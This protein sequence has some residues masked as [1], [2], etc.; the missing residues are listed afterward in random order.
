[1]YSLMADSPFGKI[2]T[3]FQTAAPRQFQ[4]TPIAPFRYERRG[5]VLIKWHIL[6]ADCLITIV[7]KFT[8][9]GPKSAFI[10]Y[11]MTHKL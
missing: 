5:E 1:M 6:P 10:N 11:I 4:R 3:A 2:R 8:Y 9:Y 7:G